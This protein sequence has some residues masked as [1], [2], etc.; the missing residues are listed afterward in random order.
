[1]LIFR[2]D[3]TDLVPVTVTSAIHGVSW[4]WACIDIIRFPLVQDVSSYP[5]SI[6]AL[7]C[8][9]APEEKTR[10]RC[11][12]ANCPMRPRGEGAAMMAALDE[13]HKF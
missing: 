4:R 11:F 7:A 3:V 2:P 9:A 12:D 13:E 1:M 10:F 5:A 6:P 8:K